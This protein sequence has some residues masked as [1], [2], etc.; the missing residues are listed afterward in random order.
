MNSRRLVSGFCGAVV[1]VLGIWLDARGRK[2]ESQVFIMT[3]LLLA[4]PVALAVVSESYR[5][6]WL[7]FGV[8]I[9]LA[10][11]AVLLMS[12]RNAMPL[13]TFGVAIVFG[14]IEGLIATVVIVKFRN[15][16]G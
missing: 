3:C 9:A 13:P 5:R 4:A 2:L 8:A 7:L 1:A 6:R 11:H 12:V 10:L 16:F 14:A 15:A